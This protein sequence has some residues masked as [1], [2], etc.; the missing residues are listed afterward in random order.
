MTKETAQRQLERALANLDL[1]RVAGYMEDAGF[2]T[3]RDLLDAAAAAWRM[4][5]TLWPLCKA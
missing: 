4:C 2:D 1:D 3:Q 5:A